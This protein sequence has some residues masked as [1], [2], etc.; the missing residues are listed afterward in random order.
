MKL[1]VGL[2][3]PGA[4]YVGTR[5]NAGF[6]VVDH[7]TAKFAPGAIPRAKFQAHAVDAAIGEEKCLLL[8]P[9]TYM[10]RS[11]ASVAE[12]LAF[13]KLAPSTDLLVI[14]D[15]LYLPVG[16]ARLRPRGGTAGHNGLE[17]IHRALGTDSYARLRVGVGL[18]PAGGK[19]PFMDQADFV[20]ARFAPEEKALFEAA[21]R[22]AAE[23]AELWVRCGLAH[24]MNFVNAPEDSGR[25]KRRQSEERQ[26]EL[27]DAEGRGA[28]SS[29]PKGKS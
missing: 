8:K 9:T 15:D 24:A 12:A 21:V 6:T 18:P 13:F 16:S 23:G 3:N 1:I 7:L 17:D 10:N 4:E 19:P 22:K 5:H 2:G 28:D 20:L 29:E 11:G 25:P 26:S 27:P 14:V